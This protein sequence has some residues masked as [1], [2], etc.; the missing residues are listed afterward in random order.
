MRGKKEV[1]VTYANSYCTEGRGSDIPIAVGEM[2][3]P[4][5]II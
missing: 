3:T 5:T 1:F 2:E 4:A